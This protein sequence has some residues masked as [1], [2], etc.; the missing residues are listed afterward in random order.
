MNISDLSGRSPTWC[1]GCGNY[2]LWAA[3][4]IAITRMNWD[5]GSFVIVYGIGC[6]GNM[7]DFIK[8][9]GFHS[10]HGRA[11]P[12][13]IGIKLANHVQRVVCVVGDGDCYGEGGNH[14]LHALRGNH[15]MTLIVHDNRVYGL[16]TG[17]TAPTS[18]KGYKSKST[19]GGVIEVPVNA[20]GL[21][22]MGG[23]SLVVQ[24]YA[25]D[26][27]YLSSLM[28]EALSHRGFA[29]VNVLQPC[30]TFN[31]TNTYEYYKERVYKVADTGYTPL[32]KMDALKL[33]MSEDRIPTGILYRD[34]R[35]PFHDELPQ[36]R[37]LPLVRQ[38][39]YNRDLSANFS[40]FI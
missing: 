27:P 29:L 16:T 21:A 7:T 13:A 4:K 28:V 6:S 36:L 34:E 33:V 19:P 5:M 35:P 24:G 2:G 14:F 3:L 30:V 8:S 26:T 22:V 40:A 12:N 25:G 23:A 17:Q 37:E 39:P 38:N 10:L 32:D 1:P 9:H 11:I 15:D 20:P 18:P 31:K